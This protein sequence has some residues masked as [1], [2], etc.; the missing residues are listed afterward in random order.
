[1]RPSHPTRP[2][3]RQLTQLAAWAG[4]PAPR[5]AVPGRFFGAP[6]WPPPEACSLALNC[7]LAAR[8][9]IPAPP[10]SGPRPLF[11][12]ASVASASALLRG[13]QF[14]IA[15]LSVATETIV[16]RRNKY[17]FHILH[18][19]AM[20]PITWQPSRIQTDG[21]RQ[22]AE[23]VRCL[24]EHPTAKAWQAQPSARRPPAA[25]GG[26][27]ITEPRGARR[28]QRASTLQGQ[29]RGRAGADPT[30]SQPRHAPAIEPP[31]AARR[32]PLLSQG[33]M[34]SLP[35]RTSHSKELG[36]PSP[37]HGARPRPVGVPSSQTLKAPDAHQRA[38][39]PQGRERGRAG[40][41][42]TRSQPCHAPA[43]ESPASRGVY[44]PPQ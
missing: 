27:V 28:H 29:E 43:L 34:V 41:D 3:F 22:W 40:A 7:R 21:E 8:A 11:R 16:V 1:M 42:P 18:I 33:P 15:W 13:P 23:T 36:G 44:A 37:R 5:I 14:Q 25:R 24:P 12:G 4:I 2:I 10:N 35:P 9:G 32:P 26:S 19:Y 17:R 20:K 38:S 31:Q 39:T 30:R 6:W